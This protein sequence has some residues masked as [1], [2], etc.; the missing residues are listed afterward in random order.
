MCSVPGAQLRQARIE[1]VGMFGW[2]EI[3]GNIRK[4]V[5]QAQTLWEKEVNS[6]TRLQVNLME[7]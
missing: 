2:R 6:L 3:V 5:K 7:K 1:V 4:V